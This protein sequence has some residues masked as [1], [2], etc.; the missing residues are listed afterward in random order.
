MSTDNPKIIQSMINAEWLREQ[1]AISEH[2][3]PGHIITISR[4]CGSFGE[5]I[6]QHISKQLEVPCF[7]KQLVEQIAQ[8][9]GVDT[10]LFRQ[11]EQKIH[12]MKPTWLETVFSDRPWLQAKYNKNLVTV[13]LGISRVGGVIL[14]RGANYILG[15]SACFRLRIVAPLSVRIERYSKHYDVDLKMAE[16]KVLEIDAERSNFVK[17]IYDRDINNPANYDLTISTERFNPETAAQL[18]LAAAKLGQFCSRSHE[19]TGST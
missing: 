5:D 14:G 16:K 6:A 3:D 17:S 12:R 1:E 9:A 15:Q 19:S 4:Q 18:V 2:A 7:D 10:D 13:L 8:S 11:L